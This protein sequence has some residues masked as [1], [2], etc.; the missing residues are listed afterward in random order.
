[1]ANRPSSHVPRAKQSK[2][3]RPPRSMRTPCVARIG[4]RRMRPVA[5]VFGLHRR[6]LSWRRRV[7]NARGHRRPS[8][9]MMM[10]RARFD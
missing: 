3:L 1:M 6:Q 9:P 8:A 7:I 4:R 5:Q 10:M 2:A